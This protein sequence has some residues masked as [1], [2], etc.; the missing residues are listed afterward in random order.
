MIETIDQLLQRIDHSIEEVVSVVVF[1]K[2]MLKCVFM[3]YDRVIQK[4]WLGIQIGMIGA[5][6]KLFSKM[7]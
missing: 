4:K 7:N 2:N 1:R 6:G 3:S 5:K